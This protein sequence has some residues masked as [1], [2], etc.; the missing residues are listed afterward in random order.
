MRV[1]AGSARRLQLVTVPGMDTR[2]TADK[3]K[4]TLFNILQPHVGGAAFLDLFAGSGAIGIEA[5]SRGAASC[6]FV[7]NSRRAVNCIKQNLAH[8][9]LE[10]RGHIL[11]SD[12]MAALARLSREGESFDIIF[13]DPPYRGDWYPPV[14][15]RI[16]RMGLLKED[17]ILVAEALL[18][19]DFSW[20]RELPFE[21]LRRKEYKTN[22]HIFWKFR[23]EE[24]I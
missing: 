10:D 17:G 18:V 20:M 12:C 14:I 16:A 7:E 5:L 4:E 1:I 13:L 23:Q 6:V 22:Q 15:E 11:A 2:P 24:D 9:H 3:Y 8:T 19:E 21:E